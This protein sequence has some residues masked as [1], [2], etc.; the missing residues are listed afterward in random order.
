[1]KWLLKYNF[2]PCIEI[3]KSYFRIDK[4]NVLLALTSNLFRFGLLC[5]VG[6]MNA[7]Y[8][9]QILTILDQNWINQL[10]ENYGKNLVMFNLMYS[11]T[12]SL[13]SYKNNLMKIL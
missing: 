2:E 12:F 4:C 9:V 10:Q 11:F 1:M 3:L 8:I 13:W 6:G 5:F 7:S